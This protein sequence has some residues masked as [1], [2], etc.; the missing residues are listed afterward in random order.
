MA[1]MRIYCDYCKQSYY[2]YQHS[3]WKSDSAR[4]CPHCFKMID[5]QTWDNIIV[6]AFGA[7]MDANQQLVKDTGF[8]NQTRFTVNFEEDYHFPNMAAPERQDQEDS[9]LDIELPDLDLDN[10]DF[11]IKL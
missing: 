10:L 4:Q 2:V 5:R 3:N 7:F 8:T 11:D 9:F 1:Q 6:P